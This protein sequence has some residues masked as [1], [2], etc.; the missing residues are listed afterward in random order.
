MNRIKLAA[1]VLL[2][3]IAAGSCTETGG[4]PVDPQ[5]SSSSLLP[6]PI[7]IVLDPLR[8]LDPSTEAT[9]GP[10]GGRLEI[11][12]GHWIDFPSGALAETTSL[13]AVH[14][15][16]RLAV[17]FGPHGLTFP[18]EALP[19]LNFRLGGL[20]LPGIAAQNLFI[21]YLDD[22][23]N[24]VEILPTELDLGAGVVRAPLRHFSTYALATDR[25]DRR[26]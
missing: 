13:T 21:V 18:D 24:L 9:I 20:L 12:G 11:A 17:E 3:G 25:S 16:L 22:Q 7:S 5:P 10:E 6:G 8:L 19:T 14:Q 23:G 15:P 1:V 4:G 2:T 26:Y